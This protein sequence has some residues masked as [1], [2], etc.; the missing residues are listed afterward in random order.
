MTG[1]QP[2]EHGT[3]F[4]V[5]LGVDQ[6]RHQ[7]ARSVFRPRGEERVPGQVA[8]GVL[9]DHYAGHFQGDAYT[10]DRDPRNLIDANCAPDGSEQPVC[11]RFAVSR[12][13]SG[14]L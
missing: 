3:P 5:K 2:R 8:T 14:L 6:A 1:K 9:V 11:E 12:A 10:V 7:R 13:S 4:K